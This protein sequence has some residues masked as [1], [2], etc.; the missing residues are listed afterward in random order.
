MESFSAS[1]SDA[2]RSS[3]QVGE[4]QVGAPSQGRAM[5][6]DARRNYEHIVT[7]AR[8]TFAELG[9]EVPLDVIARRARVGSGTL[10]RHFPTREVLVEAVYR[11]DI[12]A[13]TDRAAEFAATRDPRVA[14]ECWV[15]EQL[16]PALQ[17]P[18]VATTL[19]DALARAPQAFS[20]SK[21][22]FNQA[23][24]ELAGAA[25]AAGAVRQDV[26]TRDILRMAHSIAVAS[27]D[28]PDACQRMLTIMFDGLRPAPI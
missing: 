8:E 5:R 2:G 20:Q 13:L 15:R 9:P 23:A 24:D 10:N 22:Q 7:S 11:S 12:A 3:G 4:D 21:E 14:L 19:K 28:A 27:E 6:A 16:V 1:Q 18:G 25:R 17:Q 26:E